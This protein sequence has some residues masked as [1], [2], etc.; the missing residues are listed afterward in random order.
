[1]MNTETLGHFIKDTGLSLLIG[2]R[3][4]LIS[5]NINRSFDQTVCDGWLTQTVKEEESSLRFSYRFD[6]SYLDYSSPI[7]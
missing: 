6:L 5:K 3:G 2:K 7:A 1:M 4:I